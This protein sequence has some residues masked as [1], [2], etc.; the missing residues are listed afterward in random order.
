[1]VKNMSPYIKKLPPLETL[2]AFESV[3]R[4]GSFT[5]A[6]TELYLT[7]SAVSKQIRQL[8]DSLKIQLFERKPRGVVL[9][10][11]G[12]ELHQTTQQIFEKLQYRII[13]LQTIH[14]SNSVTILATHA[15]TQFWLFP[16]L[17]EF[18]KAYPNITVHV[19]A[20]NTMDE[21]SFT[22]YDLGILYGAG[23]WS[24]LH[25]QRLIPEVIYPV[26]HPDI[27]ISQIHSLRDLAKIPLV[28]INAS[29][30]DCLDWKDWFQHFDMSYQTASGSPTFNQLTLAFHAVQQGMGIGLAWSFMADELVYTGKLQQV[31]QFKCCT[32]NGEFLVYEKHRKLS[33]TAQ[34]FHDWLINS[35]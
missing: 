11:A 24:S 25:S 33:E 12:E 15:L 7:Q 29:A 28:Q 6:A 3:G 10:P 17:V 19:D 22:Q 23:H 9:T 21:S 4:H 2:I 26:A 5:Q 1:M 35:T 13:R 31:T 34:I 20:I 30:W 18:H 27:D 32:G 16:K 8:E 14:Q